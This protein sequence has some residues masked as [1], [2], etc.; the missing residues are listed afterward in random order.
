MIVTTALLG[1]IGLLTVEVVLLEVG[2]G[3][4]V[5]DNLSF[6]GLA[7]LGATELIVDDKA[8]TACRVLGE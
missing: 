2:T 8:T 1:G 6:M 4:N 5:V 7:A 3:T